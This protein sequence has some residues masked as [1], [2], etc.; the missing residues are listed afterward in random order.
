MF[1]Y[2]ALACFDLALTHGKEPLLAVTDQ[3]AALRKAIEYVFPQSHH[4]LCMWHITQKLP[5]KVC[6]DVE[7]DLEFK[8]YFHKLIWNVHIGPE[9]F[10]QRW[11]SLIAMFNLA[12]NNWLSEMFEIRDRWI[13]AYFKDLPMCC[14]MKTTSRSE[15]SNAFFRIHSHH[16]NMLVQFML[17]FEA[18]MEKQ[19][20]TQRI[21]D[22]RAFDSTPVMFTALPIE[23][24]ACQVYSRSIFRE[25]Q[26]EIFKGLHYCSQISA[27][28]QDGSKVCVIRQTNKS[29]ET[30]L[31]VK[32]VI[33]DMDGSITKRWRKDVLPG[34]LLEKRHRYG[35]CI[36]ETNQLASDIHS[37][38]E[39][40]VNRLRN[41][42][43]KLTEFL[44][45]VNDLKKNL[46][47]DLPLETHKPNNEDVFQKLLGV[48]TPN[49]VVVKVPKG[50][51]NK[52][53]GT[54]GARMIGP[55]EKAKNKAKTNQKGRAC[56]L[57]DGFGHNM[58]TCGRNKS[59]GKEKVIEESEDEEEGNE[60]ETSDHATSDTE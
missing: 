3:D 10:E 12:D 56:S 27:N 55:G 18:A 2:Y 9:E 31:N 44:A 59:K 14:L 60:N 23:R 17:C 24:H 26:K 30:V 15:S 32:V 38:I 8:K 21:A 52:G 11:H 5:G 51:R 7:N 20:Y 19:R 28:S 39:Y 40:C 54:G 4:R 16:G 33:S 25:V 36:E 58:R 57:C 22:N 29:N 37:T 35:P 42:T 6:G 48:T 50:I 13:P 53:C 45:K 34:H 43:E 41:D 1:K 46:D 47:A 49:E